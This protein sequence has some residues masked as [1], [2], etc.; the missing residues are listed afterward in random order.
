MS[1]RRSEA[2]AQVHILVTGASGF[3]GTA[4]LARLARNGHRLTALSRQPQGGIPGVNWE[5]VHLDREDLPPP[6]EKVDAVVHCAGVAHSRSPSRAAVQALNVG[7]TA[8]VLRFASK[9]EVRRVVLLSS[10]LVQ[11]A[12]GDRSIVDEDSSP[13]PRGVYGRS[14]AEAERLLREWTDEKPRREAVAFRLPLVYGQG[15]RGNLAAWIRAIARGRYWMIG[16]GTALRTLL[17]RENLVDAIAKLLETGSVPG[18]RAYL[19]GDARDYSIQE[20]Y[21][22]IA[23]ACG[24]QPVERSIPMPPARTAARLGDGIELVVRR[25]LFFSSASLQRLTRP[26]RYSSERFRSAYGWRPIVDFPGHVEQVVRSVL[27][28]AL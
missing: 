26:A 4:V 20:L 28:V 24:R 2:R 21:E 13:S 23:I 9:A 6:T 25:P 27:S 3:I 17:A 12:A 8:K 22:T 16:D 19:L 1:C 5:V 15:V 10:V 11:G 7:G 14:K 18:F